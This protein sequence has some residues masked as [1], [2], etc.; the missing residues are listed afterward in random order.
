MIGMNACL[1]FLPLYVRVLGVT[2][3]ADAQRW[4]GFVYAGAFLLSIFTVPLWGA[5]GD[6]YGKKLMIVRA[7]FG[8]TLAMFLM[9]FAQN[10]WQLF[11]LRV[12]QGGVSGFIAASLSLVSSTTPI[13]KRGY[14]MSLMQTSISAGTVVGP[15]IG[16]VMTD[17]FGVRSL[18]YVV[19]GLCFISGVVV[20]RY[21]REDRTNAD[22]HEETPSVIDNLRFA[23]NTPLLRSLM[24]CVVL[25]QA[26][27]SFTPSIMAYFLE[28]KGA[29][30]ST[31][32]TI[33][34]VVVGIVGVLTVMVAPRWGKLSDRHGFAWTLVRILPWLGV[35][36]LAQGFIP[37][38]EWIFPLRVAL[39]VFGGAVIPTLFTA[40]SKNAPSE[41]NGG[42]IGLASSATLVG[43]LFAPILCGW[44]AAT[45]GM[46]WCFVA[47]GLLFVSV[48][49]MVWRMYEQK[50]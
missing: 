39:G 46:V 37:S 24:L 27:T 33:T 29:P 30:P 16:G 18:F 32:A 20:V 3:F 15:L 17:M 6:K 31:L 10:V 34:G 4:T 42:M 50:T 47:S 21:V 25:V 19:S 2:D 1:P 38:Y 49:P 41:R 13:H 7:I 36:T 12:F 26:G 9:G 14:A 35:A 40:L 43:G 44:I 8:L 11:F 22:V 48:L 5:L 28:S 23:W 45:L